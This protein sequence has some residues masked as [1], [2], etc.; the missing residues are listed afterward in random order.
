MWSKN[1]IP[2]SIADVP[3]PSRFRRIEMRVSLVERLIC[4]RRL[5][6]SGVIKANQQKKQ[7]RFA[8][9]VPM[10]GQHGAFVMM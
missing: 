7:C 8:H 3:E 4:E 2:V 10:R 6:I 1:G 5:F 9:G